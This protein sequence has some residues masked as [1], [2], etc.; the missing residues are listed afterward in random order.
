MTCQFASYNLNISWNFNEKVPTE[1]SV[2]KIFIEDVFF[3]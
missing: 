2:P 3:E 1:Q